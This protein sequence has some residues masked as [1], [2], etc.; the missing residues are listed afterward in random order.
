MGVGIVLEGK[1][2]I[3]SYSLEGKEIVYNL[4]GAGEIFGN[5]LLFSSDE[6]F[7]GSVVGESDG[8]ILYIDK[9]SLVGILQTNKD[10]LLEYLKAQSDFGKSLNARIK[11]LS[12]PSPE[13][14][15][16]YVLSLGK[17]SIQFKSLTVLSEQLHIKRETLSRLVHRLKKD[18]QIT[19]EKHRISV[20][21][22]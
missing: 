21:K 16:D 12:L 3:R 11:L 4:L 13:E 2:R 8:S 19:L 17:G 18:G 9:E 7:R 20:V 14:R 22:N 1:L 6:T 15:L 10:F 5:N